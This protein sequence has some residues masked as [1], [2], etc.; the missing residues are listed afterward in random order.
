MENYVLEQMQEEEQ[1]REAHLAKV[2]QQKKARATETTLQWINK[3][4][5]EKKKKEHEEAEQIRFQKEKEVAEWCAQ[6]E[7]KQAEILKKKQLEDEIH[8]KVL[9][10]KK[11]KSPG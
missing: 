1:K 7:A 4:E 8:K 11:Q 9:A 6:E 5:E 2:A 10:E 3:L